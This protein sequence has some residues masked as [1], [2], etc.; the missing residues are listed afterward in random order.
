GHAQLEPLHLLEALLAQ[1][2]GTT[3]PLLQA[4]GADP[5]AVRNAVTAELAKLPRVS[6][7]TVSAAAPSRSLLAVFNSAERHAAR[8]QDEYVSAEHLL[9]GVAA[10]G[11]VAAR[12]LRALGAAVQARLAA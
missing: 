6:G 1:S 5:A 4:V 2:D 7:S 9:V 11:V 3:V 8:L 10:E 12:V